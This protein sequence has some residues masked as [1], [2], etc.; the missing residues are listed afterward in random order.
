MAG[1]GEVL[2]VGSINVDLVVRVAQLPAPGQTV[3]GGVFARHH[4]GKGANQAVAAARLG[5]AVTMVGAVGDDE[6]GRGALVDLAGEGVDVSRVAVLSGQPT[7]LAL[8]VVDERGENQIAVAPGANAALDGAAVERALDG[9]A[10]RPGAVVLTGFELGDDAIVAAGHVAAAGG[11]RLLLNPAPARALYPEL[12]ALTPIM[13]PNEGEAA[14]L[15][16]ESDPRT[17]AVALAD[18]TSA[19][20][21]V[22]LGAQG[23]LLVGAGGPGSVELVAAPRV[24]AVDTT[25]AGDAFAGALAAELAAGSTL[26]QAARVAVQAAALSVRVAGARGGMP[27]RS[28]LG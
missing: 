27:R 23:A 25:G 19:P 28:E 7:G 4:G 24:E 2:I 5:A 14:A 3:S 15:T 26:T 16:S 11:L 13:L 21:V 10:P 22:T 1:A 6:F 20:V 17:A 9:W 8:I 12:L 18:M